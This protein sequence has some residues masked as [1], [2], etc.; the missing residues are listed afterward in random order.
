MSVVHIFSQ[1]SSYQLALGQDISLDVE[2]GKTHPTFEWYKDGNLFTLPQVG[3]NQYAY[4]HPSTQGVTLTKHSPI[5]ADCGMFVLRIYNTSPDTGYVD[6]APIIV[7]PPPTPILDRAEKAMASLV[8]G[9]VTSDGYNFSWGIVNEQDESIGDFPRAVID[10]SDAVADKETNQDSLSGTGS[11]DY[12]NE[13][14]F[15]VLVKG[16]LPDFSTNPLF[17][18]RSTLRKALDDLKRLFG[19]HLNLDSNCDNIMYAGSQIESLVRNDVQRPAQL[20]TFWKVIYSQDR[21]TP[22]NYSSS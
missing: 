21:Q 14:I 11:R 20:R 18:I 17:E 6:S 5:A 22:T 9:I 10:P 16:E 7:S 1:T 12:T 19:I 8:A 13:V 15:T 2:W 3:W 4:I